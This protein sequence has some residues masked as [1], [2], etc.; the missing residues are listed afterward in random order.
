[1]SF[2]DNIICRQELTDEEILNSVRSSVKSD[3]DSETIEFDNSIGESVNTT[4]IPS[5][6]QALE[7]VYELQ[8]YLGSLERVDN[9]YY[10]FVNNL[11]KLIL[12]N[13]TNGKQTQITQF[14][15]KSN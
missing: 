13:K 15:Q 2:D 14:F 5:K 10:D 4:L 12:S 9:S 7:K 1:V 8:L 6:S 3:S 11:E